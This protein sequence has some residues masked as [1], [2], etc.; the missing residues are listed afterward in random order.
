MSSLTNRAKWAQFFGF[1]HLICAL[2]FA[3]TWSCAFSSPRT[4]FT[5]SVLDFVS[6][7]VTSRNGFAIQLRWGKIRSFI[8]VFDIN[9]FGRQIN[10]NAF[11]GILNFWRVWESA[12]HIFVLAARSELFGKNESCDNSI[13]EQSFFPRNIR[14]FG[15][16]FQIW[17]KSYCISYSMIAYFVFTKPYNFFL[18]IRAFRSQQFSGLDQRPGQFAIIFP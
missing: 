4:A 17:Q 2:A 10:F 12:V 1:I 8:V 7:P 11:Q 9:Y 18:P 6:G 16:F 5:T 15:H 3:T 14:L 13:E